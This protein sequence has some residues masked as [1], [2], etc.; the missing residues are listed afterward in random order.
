[1]KH[2]H[3]M[4]LVAAMTFTSATTARELMICTYRQIPNA[5]TKAFELAPGTAMPCRDKHWDIA[6]EPSHTTLDLLYAAGWHLISAITFR[7][8]RE[9]GDM[10]AVQYYLEK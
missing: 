10:V 6:K 4:G 1:M 8:A 3:L 9:D 2:K 7:T 5:A